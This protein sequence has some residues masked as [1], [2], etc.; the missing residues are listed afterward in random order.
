MIRSL[1]KLALWVVVVMVTYNYF[2]GNPAEKAQSGRV[3]QGVGQVFGEIKSLVVSE[4]GKFDGGK[5]DSALDKMGNVIGKLRDHGNQTGDKAL[6]QQTVQMEDRRQHIEHQL[7]KTEKDI[8][9][10]GQTSDKLQQ[11]A[12]L[13]RE[14]ERL[15]VDLQGLVEKVSPGASKR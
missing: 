12:N 14:L 4:K 13:A 10:G 1:L 5:Y 7:K 15:N 8:S 11:A 2:W 6:V 3:F 9:A